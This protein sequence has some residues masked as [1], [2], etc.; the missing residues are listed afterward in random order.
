MRIAYIGQTRGTSLQRANALGRLSHVV[1]LIDPWSWIDSSKWGSRWLFHAG[2]VGLD[3]ALRSRILRLV[4]RIS[5]DLI[6]VNQGEFLGPTVL[7]G[8]RRLRVPI[9]NY[10]ADNPFATSYEHKWRNFLK[11]VGYYDLIVQ[12]FEDAATRLKSM[13]ARNVLRVY[14]SADEVVHKRV[15]LS[16]ADIKQYGSEVS[17]IGQWT[18]ERGRFML[19]VLN[20]GVPLS[21]W[22]D[23]WRKGKEWDQIKHR[24][25]GP[26]MFDERFAKVIQASKISLCFLYKA[27]G[28][29]HTSRSLEIPSLGTLL[30]AERSNEHLNLYVDRH[31]AVFW[32][33]AQECARICK[34]LL[35]NDEKRTRIAEAGYKRALRN[36]LFNEPVMASIISAAMELHMKQKV[37]PSASLERRFKLF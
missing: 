32:D 11:A 30:C 10:S 1:T 37:V 35:E 14:L 4:S 19:E 6:W 31:E 3:Y 9:I 25:R 8:L 27:A 22:G 18:P 34:E 5:P 12:T 2:G 29:L 23:R 13:G 7:R 16:A 20:L 15:I 24:W 21:F 28:N 17:F 26:G 33:T 36:S